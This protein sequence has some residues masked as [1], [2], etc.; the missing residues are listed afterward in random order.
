MTTICLRF[1]EKGS[2]IPDIL[3]GYREQAPVLTGMVLSIR[4]HGWLFL[5]L[6]LLMI[7]CAF[8]PAT[9]RVALLWH[10]RGPVAVLEMERMHRDL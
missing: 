1:I 4:S 8:D 6:P 3:N 10:R 7:G 5:F 9:R 2:R